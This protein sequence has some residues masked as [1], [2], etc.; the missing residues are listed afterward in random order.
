MTITPVIITSNLDRLVRFYTDLFAASETMRVPDEGPVFF[1]GLQ[2]GESALGLVSD[3]GAQ[4]S[5]V[6]PI[7]L[8]I[9]VD[10]VDTH[11]KRVEAAGGVVHGPPN[12]MPWGQ[13]VAHVGD[14]DGNPVNLTQEIQA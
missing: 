7:L 9:A 2:V 8:S 1:I 4:D 5:A 13:R 10:D 3:S 12:D 6:H 14:P 11:L